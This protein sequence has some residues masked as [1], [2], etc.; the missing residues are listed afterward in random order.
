MSAKRRHH[1]IVLLVWGINANLLQTK[2]SE[3]S[4]VRTLYD[5]CCRKSNWRLLSFS[6]FRSRSRLRSR[7]LI[8]QW[9]FKIQDIT[10]YLWHHGHTFRSQSYSIDLVKT[11]WLSWNLTTVV[12]VRHGNQPMSNEKEIWATDWEWRKTNWDVYL[13]SQFSVSRRS[14]KIS[15]RAIIHVTEAPICLS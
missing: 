12:Y 1:W 2:I 11:D 10:F 8:P 5:V 4:I 6:L 14:L 15:T 7:A 9:K 13:L 3:T